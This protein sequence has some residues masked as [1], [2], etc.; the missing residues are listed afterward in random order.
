MIRD[1]SFAL[2]NLRMQNQ[3][4]MLFRMPKMRFKRLQSIAET[5][6]CKWLPLSTFLFVGLM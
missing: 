3:R 1:K 2:Q 6:A 5:A 4:W